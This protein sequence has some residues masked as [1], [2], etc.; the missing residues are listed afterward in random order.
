VVYNLPVTNFIPQR[1]IRLFYYGG[2]GVRDSSEASETPNLPSGSSCKLYSIL[3]TPN[4]KKFVIQKLE[5]HI[6]YM[7]FSQCI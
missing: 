2:L 3:V 5:L 4:L 6:T 1:W 7:A